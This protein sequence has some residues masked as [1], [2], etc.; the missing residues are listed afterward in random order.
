[1]SDQTSIWQE[2]HQI[3]MARSK[4]S[5][6]LLKEYDATVYQPALKSLKERCAAAGHG[7]QRLWDNGIGWAWN[8]C[9]ACGARV[10]DAFET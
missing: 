8:E 10:G 5:Q 7:R 3:S 4:K 2:R 1:V 9:T 6:E